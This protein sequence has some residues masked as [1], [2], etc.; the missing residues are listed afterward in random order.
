MSDIKHN[1]EEKRSGIP[2]FHLL[3]DNIQQLP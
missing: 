3:T 1:D 2:D